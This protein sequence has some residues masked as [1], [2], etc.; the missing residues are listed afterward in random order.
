MAIFVKSLTVVGKSLIILSSVLLLSACGTTAGNYNNSKSTYASVHDNYQNANGSMVLALNYMKWS[1]NR[2]N[3]HDRKRQEQAVF[4]AL[5]N[6][7][8]GEV[9]NWYNGDTGAQGKVRVAMSYPQGSGYC[10]VLQS[11]IYYNGK[12][13]NFQETACINAVDNSWRFVR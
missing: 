4:F 13:R 2:M 12:A 9:T 6:L 10:R 3:V 7:K 5:N 1:A 11:E 8:N